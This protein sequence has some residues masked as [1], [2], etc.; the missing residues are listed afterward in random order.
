MSRTPWVPPPD[1]QMKVM[2]VLPA[3]LIGTKLV[4]PAEYNVE[5]LD[6]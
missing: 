4:P 2:E 3:L 1:W 5:K 6:L